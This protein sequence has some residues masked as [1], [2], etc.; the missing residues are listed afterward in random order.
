MYVLYC[1]DPFTVMYNTFKSMTSQGVRLYRYLYC[2]QY[3][4][5]CDFNK[6]Y[7]YYICVLFDWQVYK[8]EIIVDSHN[9]FADDSNKCCSKFMS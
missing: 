2:I 5:I 9:L 6:Y 7:Y 8:S 4:Y 3:I 1:Q